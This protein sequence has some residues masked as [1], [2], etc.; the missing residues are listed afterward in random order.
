M[1]NS[2]FGAHFVEAPT[3]KTTT[4]NL[5]EKIVVSIPQQ[6]MFRNNKG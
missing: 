6:E 5:Q 1:F 2:K 3:P 4:D